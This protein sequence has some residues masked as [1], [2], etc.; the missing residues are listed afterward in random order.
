MTY[1]G[2]RIAA[3]KKFSWGLEELPEIQAPKDSR[4]RP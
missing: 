2:D 1:A 3:I 4:P